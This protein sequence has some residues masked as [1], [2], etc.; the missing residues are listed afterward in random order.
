MPA[1][2][3]TGEVGEPSLARARNGH[4]VVAWLQVV[5]DSV[6]LFAAEYDGRAWGAPV[7]LQVDATGTPDVMAAGSKFYIGWAYKDVNGFPE[8]RTGRWTGTGADVIPSIGFA[9]VLF[10]GASYI[11]LWRGGTYPQYRVNWSSS[12]DGITWTSGGA[13]VTGDPRVWSLA[14]GP[15]GAVAVVEENNSHAMTFAFWHAGALSI[16]PPQPSLYQPCASAVGD[17]D[18]VIVCNSPSLSPQPIEAL[19]HANNA[20]SNVM[21]STSVARLYPLLSTDGTDFRLDYS[22]GA[23]PQTL[24]MVLHSGAWSSVVQDLGI[25]AVRPAVAACGSWFSLAGGQRDLVTAQGAAPYVFD[26]A[27]TPLTGHYAVD[28][29]RDR[30]SAA[31]AAPTPTSRDQTVL[32]VQ[33]GL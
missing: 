16:A 13:L 18:A 7:L 25:Y 23:D 10:D 6:D 3:T 29:S 32:H 4:V 9:T 1:A 8:P 15:A 24:S 28:I 27:T 33:I 26:H 21:A 19:V 30:Y 2:A 11:A 12:D 5:A 14:S 17:A 22:S 31:W 20:W